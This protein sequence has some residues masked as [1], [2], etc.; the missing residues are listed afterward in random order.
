MVKKT[1]FVR[2]DPKFVKHVEFDGFVS[3]LDIWVCILG[4]GECL[5]FLEIF[6]MDL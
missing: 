1:R 3:Q 6:E 2:K 4:R 5:S